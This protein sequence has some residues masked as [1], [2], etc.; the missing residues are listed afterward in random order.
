MKPLNIIIAENL[1]IHRKNNLLSQS[2]VAFLLN[3]SDKSL[4]KW[5]QGHAIP[6][7]DILMK[8]TKIYNVT[9][10]DIVTDKDIVRIDERKE[11]E[12]LVKRQYNRLIISLL[13]ISGVWIIATIVYSVLAMANVN[14]ASLAFLWSLPI[15]ALMAYVFNLFWGKKSFSLFIISI[16]LWM[17]L[18]AFYLTLYFIK[19]MREIFF[20]G[21]PIQIALILANYV[22]KTILSHNNK[23]KD[24]NT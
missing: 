8:L 13:S 6:S 24:L 16:T 17:I 14:N 18:A 21:F 19:P 1:T 22:S 2:E 15:T 11:Y 9:L 3:Y 12:K 20:I 23:K 7:L 10:D 5:E 4:S